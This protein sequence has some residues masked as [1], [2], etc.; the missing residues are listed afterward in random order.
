MKR[1]GF[2]LMVMV[3]LVFV[4]AVFAQG[5]VASALPLW[6]W[7]SQTVSVVLGILAP[8]VTSLLAKSHW[9]AAQKRWVLVAVSM[10]ATIA[11]GIVTKALT[12]DSVTP[13]TI[14]QTLA[15]VFAVGT[16]TYQMFSQKFGALTE[17]T[18]NENP[19]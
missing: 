18:T 13:E 9:S 11:V 19:T 10:V 8:V 12:K 6:G 14:F 3:L 2:G 5:D 1:F 16:A 4:G 15:T 17:A 7:Q